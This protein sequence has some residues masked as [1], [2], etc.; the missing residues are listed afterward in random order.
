MQHVFISGRLDIFEGC[1]SS[2]VKRITT[3][4]PHINV[5]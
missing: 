2:E 3:I 5:F 1:S 4:E